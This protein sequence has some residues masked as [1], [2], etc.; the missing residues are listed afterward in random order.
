MAFIFQKLLK[1]IK[2]YFLIVGILTT[3]IC[4]SLVVILKQNLKVVSQTKTI[5]DSALVHVK[6]EGSLLEGQNEQNPFSLNISELLNPSRDLY[7]PQ[8]ESFL[9][10]LNRDNKVK[11]LLIELGSLQG[12]LALFSELRD[13]LRRF[14]EESKK[15][16][17]IWFASCDTKSY[18]L[19]SVADE[20]I[21]SPVGAL[22]VLGPVVNL[23]YFG[24]ALKKLGVGIDV[25]R[26]GEYKSAF[27]P[28]IRNSPSKE[29]L[30][31]Y[32][33]I[34]KSVRQKLMETMSKSSKNLNKEK[35]KKVFEKSLFTSH[36][37]LDKKLVTS[38]SYIHESKKIFQEKHQATFYDYDDYSAAHHPIEPVKASHG[39]KGIALIEAVGTIY[40][41]E[42]ASPS[43]ITPSLLIKELKWAREE[44]NI[45][46]VV[47]RISSPGGSALAS[48]LIWEEVR[49]LAESKPLV[50]SMGSTAASGGY[51]IAAPA[52]KIFASPYTMTGSIGVIG[53]LPNFKEFEEKYGVSFFNH[54]MSKR[55]ALIDMGS[56]PSE[57]D[58]KVLKETMS[59]VYDQFITK[60]SQGRKLSYQEVE[61]VAK[62][63]V[64]SGSQAKE[65]GLVDE[66][67]GL[68]EALQE[69]KL[70]AGFTKEDRVP[71]QRWQPEIKS[72]SDCFKSAANMRKCFS[73]GKASL[74][75]NNIL[76]SLSLESL[77][78]K[79]LK[80][81]IRQEL[82]DT[83]QVI[84]PEAL[85]F[86]IN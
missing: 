72:L 2:G 63:Q 14:K 26:N 78:G 22:Q 68:K 27:E 39:Q 60:V 11:G 29:S 4:F 32:T 46:S 85:T 28:F 41:E 55:K 25:I 81:K 54:T 17:Y 5:E 50:V 6:W 61:A 7:L 48:D 8:V 77:K 18:Y 31:M 13:A 75:Q 30:E 62:G 45:K 79:E 38:L 12:S 67:G 1:I 24:E 47:L 84:W 37:A 56:K 65:R 42:G 44:D 33:A 43:L 16:V 76:P 35:L 52:K 34:E 80:N 49:R 66:I 59:F 86:E 57:E 21:M 36:E 74:K 15:P 20:M 10:Q 71:V 64:W 51:Y 19:A 73:Y 3:L 69:A 53:L 83:I 40:M 23:V 9:E 70:L 58:K 82:G